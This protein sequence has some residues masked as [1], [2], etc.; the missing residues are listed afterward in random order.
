MTNFA[1]AC[2]ALTVAVLAGVTAGC[3][4]PAAPAT[5]KPLAGKTSY[6]APLLV[7]VAFQKS[8]P[9]GKLDPASQKKFVKLLAPVV[10]AAKKDGKADVAAWFALIV[11]VSPNP[12]RMTQKERT[13][14]RDGGTKLSPVLLK[15][16]GAALA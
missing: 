10:T 7:A 15:D 11:K 14:L 2:A 16:C 5:A 3:S 6:C 1:R 4:S 13:A 12:T 9:Q 8:K